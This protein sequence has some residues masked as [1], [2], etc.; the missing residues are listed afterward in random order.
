MTDKRFSA[1]SADEQE[2]LLME[3]IM[4]YVLDIEE[5]FEIRNDLEDLQKYHGNKITVI[6]L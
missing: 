2:F 4:V 1:Y 3:G 5:G 6:Y